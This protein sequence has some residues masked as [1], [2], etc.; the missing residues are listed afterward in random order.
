MAGVGMV[1]IQNKIESVLEDEDRC[2][3]EEDSK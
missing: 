1:E 2:R 3:N